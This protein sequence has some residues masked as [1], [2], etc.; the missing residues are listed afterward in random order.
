MT[1]LL[2]CSTL[3]DSEDYRREFAKLLP[4][5]DFRLWPQIGDPAEIAAALVWQPPAGLLANLPNLKLILSLGA[6]VDHL[7][8]D[9]TLPDLPIVR[10]VDPYMTAAMC[11]YV[12]WQVMR[13]HRQEFVYL[14][15]QRAAE[16]REHR[17]PNAA[18]RRVGILGL[19]ALGSEA[20]LRLEVMGFDVAGWTSSEHK[21]RGVRCYWGTD[22]LAPFLARSDVLVC[23]LPLTAETE[24][25]LSAKLFAHLPRGAALVNCAR[26]QHLVEADLIQALDSG[27]LSA[28]S[29]DV[30]RQE[31]LPPEHPF[32][33][34]KRILVT[35][36]VA[37][38]THAPTASII[39]ADALRR[40]AAD[41]PIPHLVER[42]RG[43]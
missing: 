20:A 2:F 24:N 13:L 34:H 32:W 1:T 12:A 26:G 6:G 18:E 22:G 37:G 25:I 31:P 41:K 9:P 35:P 7:F 10:L 28:A 17:Q 4:D 42:K 23:L 40:F 27:Q 29:L 3:G 5:L 11:E 16:W 33:H 19:G 38:A 14:E 8:A 21:L 15:Q 30:F 39:Y 36:H 43:Y